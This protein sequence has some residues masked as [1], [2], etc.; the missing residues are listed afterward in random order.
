MK[1]IKTLTSITL[2]L[3]PALLSAQ[4]TADTASIN[5]NL[6]LGEVVVTGTRNQTDIRHLPMTISVVNNSQIRNSYQPSLLPVIAEQ[7]PGLFITSRGIL[8]YGVS[9]GGSGGMKIRGVGGGVTTGGINAYR[10]AS[11]VYGIDGASSGRL[12]SIDVG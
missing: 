2:I 8:G 6:T 7:V 12:L 9:K 1:L 5:R 3:L 4:N 10:R 11:S